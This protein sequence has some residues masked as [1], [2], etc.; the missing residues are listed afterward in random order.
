MKSN[1]L[2]RVVMLLS[3]D[4]FGRHWER[5]GVFIGE[6]KK[7]SFQGGCRDI[8][9]QIMSGAKCYWHTDFGPER[10][11]TTRS[12]LD[13][14][15]KRCKLEEPNVERIS[16]LASGQESP[17][18]DGTRWLLVSMTEQLLDNSITDVPPL[19]V[20][21]KEAL[22]RQWQRSAEI[23]FKYLCI[24]STTEWDTFL[25]GATPDLPAM[26][27]DYVSAIASESK[28]ETLWGFINAKLTMKQRHEIL[29]WYRSVGQSLTGEPLRLAHEGGWPSL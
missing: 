20:G 7:G 1:E 24:A 17:V 9:R 3:A 27:A 13:V 21:I 2:D 28:F 12:M 5:I 18:D 22:R 6:E 19:D 26:L 10:V 16:Q 25:R 14:L 8:V 11:R 4:W 29:S 15:M 23:D